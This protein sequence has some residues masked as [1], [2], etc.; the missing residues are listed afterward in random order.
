LLTSIIANIAPAKPA[1]L[2]EKAIPKAE[3]ALH[4]KFNGHP[5]TVEYLAQG[6]GSVALAHVIQIQN[7]EA[8]TWYEAFVDAHSGKLLSITNFV[9]DASVRDL[10]IVI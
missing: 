10:S 4:G 5:P 2:V 6:D 1:I 7:E 8:G 3:Q 9:A